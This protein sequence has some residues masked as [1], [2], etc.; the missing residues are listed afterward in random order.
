[1]TWGLYVKTWGKVTE[2]VTNGFKISD[3]SETEVTVMRSGPAPPV[4]TFV[5]VSGAAGGG[6][7][8]Y[9]YPYDGYIRTWLFN[10]AYCVD[11]PGGD[12]YAYQQANLDNDFLGGETSIQPLPGDIGPNGAAWFIQSIKPWDW[13]YDLTL[14]PFTGTGKSQST[15]YAH[16]W[17]LADRQYTGETGDG[18]ELWVGSDDGYVVFWNGTN[19]YETN[20]W[21]SITRDEDKITN[22]TWEGG[23]LYVLNAGWNHILFKINNI[24]GGFAMGLRLM[25]NDPVSGGKVPLLLPYSVVVY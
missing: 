14:L 19:I 8:I 1:L 18:L 11:N 9:E 17:I 23:D 24:T 3:G 4:G 25:I 6:P 20:V 22:T 7:T 10:G 2:A 21:R 5:T 16:V 15:I 12:E 13:S